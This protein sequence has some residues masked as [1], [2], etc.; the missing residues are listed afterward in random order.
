[1][2]Y[3]YDPA[4]KRLVVG[5]PADNRVTLFEEGIPTYLPFVGH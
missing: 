2:T 3:A 4:N 1:M 5:R